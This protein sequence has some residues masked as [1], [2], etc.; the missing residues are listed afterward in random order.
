MAFEIQISWIIFGSVYGFDLQKNFSQSMTTCHRLY[1]VSK[2]CL[3][4]LRKYTNEI[5]P[6]DVSRV[7]KSQ[8]KKLRIVEAEERNETPICE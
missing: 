1:Y 5:Y 7:E 8:T 2:V 6:N 3:R 4:L